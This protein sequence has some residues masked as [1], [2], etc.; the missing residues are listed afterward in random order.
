ME[1]AV[2]CFWRGA[3]SVSDVWCQRG[4]DVVGLRIAASVSD[5]WCQRGGGDV[6]GPRLG[7]CPFSIR[8]L[9]CAFVIH[10]CVPHP[11]PPPGSGCVICCRHCRSSAT[12][13]E[14]CKAAIARSGSRRRGWR[15]LCRLWLR[16]GR[17]APRQCA[18]SG[19]D[20]PQLGPGRTHAWACCLAPCSCVLLSCPLVLHLLSRPL[21]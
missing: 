19:P 2:R 20:F 6:V 15:G 17:Q 11:P 7:P 12:P 13:G 16:W 9:R 10:A 3:A 14:A 1:R 18:A 4:G 5:V 8:T 21:L